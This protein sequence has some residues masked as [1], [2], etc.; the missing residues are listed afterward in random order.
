MSSD[1]IKERCLANMWL[2][3][4]ESLAVEALYNIFSK[5]TMSPFRKTFMNKLI[6]GGREDFDNYSVR[7][8]TDHDGK[9]VSLEIHIENKVIFIESKFFGSAQGWITSR[10]ATLREKYSL[11]ERRILCILTVMDRH[12]EVEEA[13]KYEVDTDYPVE[14]RSLRWAEILGAF[15]KLRRDS[16]RLT[17]EKNTAIETSHSDGGF[18]A[19][20]RRTVQKR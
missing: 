18:C 7:L 1:G 8:N 10:T 5:P 17:K 4:S 14:V 6:P 3:F 16:E 15:A 9:A 11:H 19:T 2:F 20:T 12:A 13:N